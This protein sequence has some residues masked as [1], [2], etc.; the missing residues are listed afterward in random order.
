MRRPALV[1]VWV[2]ELWLALLLA[3]VALAWIWS[4][5]EGSLARSLQLANRFLPQGQQL[6]SEDVRGSLRAGGQ[7]ARLRWSMAGLSVEAQRVDVRWDPWELLSGRLRVQ[8]LQVADLTIEDRRP[9]SA[10]PLQDLVLP[11]HF[12]IALAV[13][14][15]QWIGP[16]EL[17]I[18][19]IRARYGHDGLQHVLRVDS[20]QF[21]Q[22]R[23]QGDASLLARAPLTLTLDVNGKFDVPL[24]PRKIPL[25]ARVTVRGPLARGTEPLHIVADLQPGATGAGPAAAA[26]AMRAHVRARIL[27]WAPQPVV[28]GQAR[29]SQLDLSALWPGAP[30]TRLSGEAQVQPRGSQW[31]A[32]VQVD[33]TLPGPWDKALLPVTQA[34]AVVVYAQGGWTIESLQAQAAGGTLDL[35]GHIA[36]GTGASRGPDWQARASW[37]GINPALAHSQLAPARLGGTADARG[38]GQAVAFTASVAPT[39]VQP[40]ASPLAGLRLQRASA[41]GRWVDGWLRLTD[42]QLHTDDASLQGPLDIQ[43]ASRSASGQLQLVVPG[44][45]G[46]LGGKIAPREGAGSLALDVTDAA[47]LTSWVRRLPRLSD[48]MALPD[49]RGKADLALQWQGGWQDLRDGLGSSTRVQAT[50]RVPSLALHTPGQG[51]A[52]VL[53]VQDARLVLAGTAAALTLTSSGQ[54]LRD[55]QV[56]TLQGLARGG[57]LPQGDWRLGV[58]TLQAQLKDLE[59][60]RSPCKRP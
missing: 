26:Q 47:R 31:L 56:F 25:D 17:R 16:P 48:A 30:R 60:G 22:G 50:L 24:G 34:R 57:R 1:V 43:P 40:A 12:D 4:G 10:E 35:Q 19:D 44:A 36:T 27:P 54:L 52:P 23:Y 18:T 8:Q 15:L 55:T 2:L 7:I 33:N 41:Q 11:W 53:R 28:D 20:A 6:L 5:S 37:S 45:Q 49:L 32:R 13:E 46:Q 42:M 9:A 58:E 14:R 59:T 21:A 38:D 51:A 39:G 29:Y 3:L